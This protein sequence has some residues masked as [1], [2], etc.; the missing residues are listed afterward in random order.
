M[1][2]KLQSIISGVIYAVSM[3]VEYKD[4]YTAGHQQR[5]ASLACAIGEKMGLCEDT[6]IGL[7]VAGMLHDV[8]KIAIPIEILSKPGKI[9]ESEFMVIK[10]HPKIGY[11]ILRSIKFPWPVAQVALQ[12]HERVN[13]SGYPAGLFCQAILPEA[14]II[15]VADVVEAMTANR[16]YRSAIG[17]KGALLE[18]NN[19]KGKLYD[20]KVVDAC[21]TLFDE[22]YD[23]F[24][25]GTL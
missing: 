3:M 9:S 25:G 7:R 2:G 24:N 4:P 5:V 13:G 12:H 20:S 15:A 6:I 19:N 22:S 11:E 18:L 14:K 8:G 21:L 1:N 17:K 23:L 10:D 16:A